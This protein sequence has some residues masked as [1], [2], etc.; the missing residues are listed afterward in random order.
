MI[1]QSSRMLRSVVVMSPPLYG[2]PFCAEAIEARHMKTE[3]QIASIL[4]LR[5]EIDLSVHSRAS[6]NF[7]VLEKKETNWALS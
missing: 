7:Q 3:A 1:A 6:S 2:R 5:D 4:H